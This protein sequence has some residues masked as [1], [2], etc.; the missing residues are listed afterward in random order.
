MSSRVIGRSGL[1]ALDVALLDPAGHVV[2]EIRPPD[3]GASLLARE[4]F[5]SLP[6]LVLGGVARRVANRL[7]AVALGAYDRPR[8][9]RPPLEPEVRRRLAG[10]RFLGAGRSSAGERRRQHGRQRPDHRHPRDHAPYSTPDALPYVT[11]T[12]SLS[13][14]S[15]SGRRG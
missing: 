9:L 4:R 15:S 14:F 8:R 13:S 6:L 12:S 3:H 11:L 7:A 5:V 10:S 1:S 2:A